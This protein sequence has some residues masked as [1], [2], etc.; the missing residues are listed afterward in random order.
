[1]T[2]EQIRCEHRKLAS[3]YPYKEPFKKHEQTIF[4]SS[5]PGRDTTAGGEKFYA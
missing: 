3:L 2:A 1:M 4:D 5:K